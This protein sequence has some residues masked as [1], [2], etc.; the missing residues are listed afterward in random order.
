MTSKFLE[1]LTQNLIQLT[2]INQ[3]YGIQLNSVKSDI[4]EQ[5]QRTKLLEIK[6]DS[7][8]GESDY[9]T[10]RGYCNINRI[11]ISEREANSLGRHAAKICRQKCY[12]IGKVQ[13][14]RHGK[15]NSY[16]IEVLEEVSKPYK[17]QI[18]AS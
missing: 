17:K 7:L 5:K 3:Q 16:P 13:D 9:C 8:S 4:S 6:F 11:K 12:L 2:A 1:L 15:V 10:V 18:R 14:E